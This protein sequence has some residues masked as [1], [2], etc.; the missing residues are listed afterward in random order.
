MLQVSTNRKLTETHNI[1][2]S[3]MK[4][5]GRRS[6]CSKRHLWWSFKRVPVLCGS[7]MFRYVTPG[8]RALNF[9][10][11]KPDGSNR[12]EPMR[13]PPADARQIKLQQIPQVVWRGLREKLVVV[14]RLQKMKSCDEQNIVEN[15]ENIRDQSLCHRGIQQTT[16]DEVKK[17][18]TEGESHVMGNP[19]GSELR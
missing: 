4:L 13:E 6:S 14:Q 9:P 15:L 5:H 2:T 17:T 7:N 19:T 11:C 1:I 10:A 12:Y 18:E 8:D 16:G 3:F